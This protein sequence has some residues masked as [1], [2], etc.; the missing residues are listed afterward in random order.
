MLPIEIFYAKE[1]SPAKTERKYLK[2]ERQSQ[3]RWSLS[4]RIRL[5]RAL[6]PF[7]PDF[8]VF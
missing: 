5:L 7:L 2:G 1:V 8:M 6:F 4:G 3:D